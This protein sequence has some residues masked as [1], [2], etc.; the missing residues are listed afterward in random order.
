MFLLLQVENQFI[1]II[2]WSIFV[3]NGIGEFY[4]NFYLV[5][6]DN[7]VYVV[8]CVGV[9]KVFNVDDGKEIWFVNLGEKDGWFFCLFVLLFGGVIVVGGYVYIGSEKVEVYVLNI[10][11]GIIVW[12]MKVV[13]EVLFCLV[14]SDGIVFIYISNGQ[15]QV[16]NQVDGVIKWMVNLDMF[17]L[18]LCG[19]FVLVIVFGVVIVG[20]D[21]GCVSVVLM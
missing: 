8:D 3:G 1:L 21:N 11:D 17:L 9:V 15:L 2:V 19:E 16:L 14:V 20:G 18:L 7:V 12:Q 6:V 4:F 10:S 5:M 13:G